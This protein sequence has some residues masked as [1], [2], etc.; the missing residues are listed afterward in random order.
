MSSEMPTEK[1]IPTERQ[2]KALRKARES[3]E[4]RQVFF[5]SSDAEEC[6]DE[7]W[8]KANNGYRLTPSGRQALQDAEAKG[9]ED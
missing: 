9:T 8:L 5:I 6:V 4:G 7:E 1:K 3:E 2:L